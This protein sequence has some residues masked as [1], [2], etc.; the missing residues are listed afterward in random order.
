MNALAYSALLNVHFMLKRQKEIQ[1]HLVKM[2]FLKIFGITARQFNACRVSLEGKISA[3]KESQS[4]SHAS[5]KQQITS[6][7]K[8]FSY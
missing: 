2:I 1:Q 3:C 6:L 8:K 5:L 7:D 4:T